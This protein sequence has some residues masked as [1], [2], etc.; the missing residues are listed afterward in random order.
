M[1]IVRSTKMLAL[2][3]AALVLA[4]PGIALATGVLAISAVTVV[5]A[6]SNSTAMLTV[7]GTCV[8]GP[9]PVKIFV[10]NT[11]SGVATKVYTSGACGLNAATSGKTVTAKL[12]GLPS[13]TYTVVLKQGGGLST[14]FGP[15]TLP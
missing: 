11:V 4:L 10:Q 2:S 12:V 8:A 7:T 5:P 14:P 1:S 13:G 6:T 9:Q 3:A 15:V